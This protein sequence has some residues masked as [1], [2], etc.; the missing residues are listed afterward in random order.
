M[1]L[2]CV[3]LLIC[4]LLFF[5]VSL[6]LVL[7]QIYQNEMKWNENEVKFIAYKILFFCTSGKQ[8]KQKSSFHFPI[9]RKPNFASLAFG[10]GFPHFSLQYFWLLFPLWISCWSES[11]C[12][13][14]TPCSLTCLRSL[15]AGWT[16]CSA[17]LTLSVHS[18][19]SADGSFWNKACALSSVRRTYCLLCQLYFLGLFVH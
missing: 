19:R 14:S 13:V 7:W 6:Y 5:L 10:V 4:W 18:P 2:N 12:S 1:V 3:C 8:W 15:L 16:T 17:A 11:F 9:K